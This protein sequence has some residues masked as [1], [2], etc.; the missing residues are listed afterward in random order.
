M[1][2]STNSPFT[3]APSI[4]YPASNMLELTFTI[5]SA[6]P[7]PEHPCNSS[8]MLKVIVKGNGGFLNSIMGARFWCRTI[9][10]LGKSGRRM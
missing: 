9:L 8:N 1:V 7:H 2:L 4:R 5:S 6:P 3:F 10:P